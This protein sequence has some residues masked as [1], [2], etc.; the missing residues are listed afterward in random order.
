METLTWYGLLENSDVLLTAGAATGVCP[1]QSLYETLA[2]RKEAG[3][4]KDGRD[5]TDDKRA[6]V[7]YNNDAAAAA[8]S[9]RMRRTWPAVRVWR[10]ALARKT[11]RAYQRQAC[12]RSRGVVRACGDA[13]LL[14]AFF[15]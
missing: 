15:W 5:F 1:L 9:R 4:R 11:A 6:N 12:F 3:G 14:A 10:R 2:W 7:A 13:R 8:L